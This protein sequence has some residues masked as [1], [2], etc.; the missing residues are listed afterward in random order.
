MCVCVYVCVCIM[1]VCVPY[2]FSY[3]EQMPVLVTPCIALNDAIN[4]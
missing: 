2:C 1:Y 4:F 3:K